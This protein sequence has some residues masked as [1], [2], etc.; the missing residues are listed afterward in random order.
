[1]EA[2]FLIWC[3][4]QGFF[5]KPRFTCNLPEH[6]EIDTLQGDTISATH[7]SDTQLCKGVG[8][9]SEDKKFKLNG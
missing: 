8:V 1:M 4:M 2:L 7:Q 3:P 9:D 5:D 6:P